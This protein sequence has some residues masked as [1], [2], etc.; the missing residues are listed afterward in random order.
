ML[1]H[2]RWAPV[3]THASTHTRVVYTHTPMATPTRPHAHAHPPAPRPSPDDAGPASSIISRHNKSRFAP[4]SINLSSQSTASNTC[5]IIESYL[6]KRR[7]GVLGPP[8]GKVS[9]NDVGSLLMR[10]GLMMVPRV[11]GVPHG[12]APPQVSAVLRTCHALHA[13]THTQIALLFVDDLSTAG[14]DMHGTQVRACARRTCWA[15]LQGRPQQ[16]PA[17]ARCTLSCH[18]SPCTRHSVRVLAP[19]SNGPHAQLPCPLLARTRALP[20]HALSN[21]PLCPAKTALPPPP[22]SALELL[23]QWCSIGGWH[24]ERKAVFKNVTDMQMV[25]C[26]TVNPLKKS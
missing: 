8:V 17:A 10:V 2:R 26:T 3:H 18:G 11:C 6:L 12:A 16:W 20:A 22:Q 5:Q 7:R 19:A 14:R 1:F 15:A 9:P 21:Q 23:R 25:G 24:D 4:I 13:R